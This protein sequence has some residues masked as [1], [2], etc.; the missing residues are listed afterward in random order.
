[1]CSHL[2]FGRLV[3]T[4]DPLFLG[5]LEFGNLLKVICLS[6]SVRGLCFQPGRAVLKASPPTS[7]RMRLQT[8]PVGP[9]PA[10]LLPPAPHPRVSGSPSGGAFTPHAPPRTSACFAGPRLCR[11][12]AGR[13]GDPLLGAGPQEDASL[14]THGFLQLTSAAL[15]P[16]ASS[17][18][19]R[20]RQ[21]SLVLPRSACTTRGL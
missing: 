17:E 5:F 20:L 10:S 11:A 19:Q 7:P 3:G 9:E 8:Q 13:E 4:P 2:G 18:I 14:G 16:L 15:C 6:G 1:M 12:L 21:R